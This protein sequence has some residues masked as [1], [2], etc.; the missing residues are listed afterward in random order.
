MCLIIGILLSS[1]T[2]TQPEN[3]R[4]Y[5]LY[6][7]KTNE[8]V[9]LKLYDKNNINFKNIPVFPHSTSQVDLGQNNGKGIG[10]PF[11]FDDGQYANKVVIIFKESNKCLVNYYKIKE[12]KYYDN[13]ADGM[14]NS[15]GN[16]LKYFIDTEELDLSTTCP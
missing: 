5:F 14:L 4:I 16:G 9:E 7:N 3:D 12:S 13:Y 1:C 6:T 15:Y 11:L 2:D 10:V 8:N